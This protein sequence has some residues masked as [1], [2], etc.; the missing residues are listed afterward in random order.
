MHTAWV[1]AFVAYTGQE[2]RIM[3]NSTVGSI[4]QSD[5]ERTMNKFTVYVLTM[6]LILTLN[7]AIIGGF[8]QSDS[9]DSTQ[10]L[11][12]KQKEKDSHYYIEFN[13]DSYSE[14]FFTFVRYLQLLSLMLPTSLFVT[15]E[16]VKALIAYFIV[17]DAQL[18]SLKQSRAT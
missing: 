14:G 11:S 3:M 5:V 16:V 9:I 10:E 4:K 17:N 8:W 18:I 15:V 13:Y 2:T 12:M 6:L 7:L 1:L